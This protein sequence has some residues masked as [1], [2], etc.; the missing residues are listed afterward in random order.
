MHHAAQPLVSVLMSVYNGER[1]LQQAISSVTAQTCSSWEFIIVDDASTDG[2]RKIL[3]QY[4]NDPRF[5][6]LYSGTNAGCVKSFNIGIDH[7][8]GTYTARFDADDICAADRLQQQAD[9]LTANPGVAMVASFV[10]FINDEGVF[11]GIWDDDRR[12]YDDAAI[13]RSL[14]FVNSIAHPSVM[15]RTDILKQYRYNEMQLNCEDWDLWMRL[16]ADH[17]RIEK[18]QLPL[19]QYRVHN[20]S[21]TANS[22]KRSAF[23]KNNYGYRQ[24]LKLAYRNKKFNWFNAKV[25]AGFCLNYIKLVLSNIKR[26]FRPS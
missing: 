4:E 11:T 15:I 2:T 19:L 12:N 10:N 13:R 7:C 6:I 17:R 3:Q 23:W 18:I 14:P 24:Y 20:S 5:N 16:A 25:F 22:F 1:W 9:Y 8:N 26:S 21:I